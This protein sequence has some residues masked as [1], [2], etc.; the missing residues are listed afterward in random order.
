[1]LTEVNRRQHKSFLS[2]NVIAVNPCWENLSPEFVNLY[3][4]YAGWGLFFLLFVVA[5]TSCILNPISTRG[6]GRK[7]HCC[8]K[9]ACTTSNLTSD[10]IS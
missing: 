9:Y 3:F 6:S 5:G 4:S 1:M 10:D 2:L 8:A 7:K